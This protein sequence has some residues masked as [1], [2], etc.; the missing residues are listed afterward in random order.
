[1][2]CRHTVHAYRCTDIDAFKDALQ[3]TA[4][5]HQGSFSAERTPQSNS[6]TLRVG[7]GPTGIAVCYPRPVFGFMRDVSIALGAVPFME[8]RIQ[9]GTLWDYSLLRG[10]Q[11]L[12]RF[13]TFPQYWE[14]EEDPIDILANKGNPAMVSL[15]FGVP[16][17][18]FDRYLR[19]WYSDWDE[20][21]EVYRSKL[22]RQS[23]SRGSK[24]I[25]ELR[26]T[27]GFS[28]QHRDT[29]SLLGALYGTREL[30]V[31]T[32]RSRSAT[33]PNLV[34]ENFFAQAIAVNKTF[35]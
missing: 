8:A 31:D 11:N 12:D 22:E 32:P 1:M 29:G 25:Q 19:H 28:G 2:G 34:A 16:V 7:F 35:N 18:K 9:E 17:E 27:L 30:G 5:K 10:M 21:S 26:T 20:E 23:V 15:V 3:R 14:D 24:H 6:T 13:S 4:E 33:A